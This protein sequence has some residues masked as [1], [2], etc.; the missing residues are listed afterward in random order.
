MIT[1]A[2]QADIA[3]LIVPASS[4]EFEDAFSKNGQTREH[5]LLAYT[6]GVKNMIV[7]IN[8]MDEN[9]VK[10]SEDR[11]NEIREEVRNFLKKTGYNIDTIP[12]VPISGFKGENLIERSKNM[13]WYTGPTLYE[14]LNNA[15]PP[16]RPNEKPLRIPV[17]SV[18]KIGGIGTVV[19]GRVESGILKNNMQITFDNLFE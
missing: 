13:P 4:G 1:G 11:Y 6:L 15:T 14:V 2:A 19:A 5:A 10:Y 16:K 7:C 9:T 3:M 8:K 17:Q 18:F 12:F